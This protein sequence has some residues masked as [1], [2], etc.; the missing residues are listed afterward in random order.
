MPFQNGREAGGENLA[1]FLPREG[2]DRLMRS[3]ARRFLRQC[4]PNWQG[5][6]NNQQKQQRRK[7]QPRM[8]AQRRPRRGG[9]GLPARFG[10][11]CMM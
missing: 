7:D 1:H 9:A 4:R 8:T 6:G 5:R 11:P 3:G 10:T 2:G